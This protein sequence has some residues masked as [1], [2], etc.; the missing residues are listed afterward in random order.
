MNGPPLPRPDDD[1]VVCVVDDDEE[2]RKGL[3]RLLRSIGLAVE[4][5]PSPQAFLAYPFEDRPSCLVLDVQLPGQNGL[6]L[7]AAL[8]EAE[9]HIPIVFVT[10]H[11]DVPTSV[12]AMKAGAVDFLEK[13]F[14]DR[15]LLDS[16]HRALDESRERRA[17][18]A[19]RAIIQQR[20]DSLTPREYQVLE[21]VVTGMLNK[22]VADALGAA[23]KTIK[24]QDDEDVVRAVR[25]LLRSAGYAIDTFASAEE[26]L[27]L[28]HQ[29][30]PD[31]LVLDVHLRGL[32]GF[33][34]QD[35][36]EASGRSIP[37]VFIT[38]HDDTG[39]RERAQRAPTTEY[40]SKPFEDQ[41]LLGAIHHAMRRASGH[42]EDA[43]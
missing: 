8:E 40:L 14:D 13:P 35:L 43:P 5:F 32:S 10:G 27:D 2:V 1:A 25:R 26:F 42:G 12:R 39:T 3:E 41:S 19:E 22:Q 24:V 7:Q 36:L 29:S 20:I 4:T 23:E 31:C 21:L 34:L 37:I 28:G 18:R 11:G 15:D 38:A 33:D 16:I 9:L 30:R 6:D 17:D